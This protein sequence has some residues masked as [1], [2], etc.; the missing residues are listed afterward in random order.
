MKKQTEREELAR[1]RKRKENNRYLLAEQNQFSVKFE[2][3][4]EIDPN[5]NDIA[6]EVDLILA[7]YLKQHQD[8]TNS[9]Y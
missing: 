5:T 4:L 9:T 7:Q 1:I 8:I 2:L 3:V 6:I